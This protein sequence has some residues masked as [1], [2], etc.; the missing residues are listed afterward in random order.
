MVVNNNQCKRMFVHIKVIYI[1]TF[2]LIRIN[3]NFIVFFF[4]ILWAKLQYPT[5]TIW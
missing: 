5:H 3:E 1:Y 2:V 4:L